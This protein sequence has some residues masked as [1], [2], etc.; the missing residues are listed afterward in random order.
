VKKFICIL[1][2]VFLMLG[3]VRAQADEGRQAKYEANWESLN[4]RPTPKW[5]TNAKFGIFIHWGVYAVPSWGVKGSYSEWYWKRVQD[6]RKKGGKWWQFHVQNY[7]EDFEYGDF[8]PM[9]KAELFD[10]DQWAQ[11]FRDSGAKYVVLTSKHHDGFC[12]WQSKEANKT[13]GRRWNS[14]DIGPRRDLLGDLG[15]AVRK[16]GLKMGFYY[17]LYEWFNPLWLTDKSRYIEEHLHPQFKDV[18]R[19]YKPSVIFSDGEWDLPSSEWKSEELLAWLFNESEARDD[20]VINDRWGKG[21]RHKHGG[22]YTTEYGAGLKG[23]AHPWE[24]NRG[25]GHSFGYNRAENLSDY[26][27]ARELILMLIDL[28]SRG[29][30]LLL[31]IGPTGDGR[32][33]VIMEERLIQMGDWLK[34]NGEAIYGT[35]PWRQGRQWSEGEKPEVGYGKTYKAKYDINTLT[36]KPSDGRA[37]IKA[38]FTSKGNTLYA[39][40]PRWPDRELVLEEVRCSKSTVVT[41]LGTQKPLRWKAEN[42]NLIIRIPKLSVDE[43]PCKHAYVLKL[44]NVN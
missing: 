9:F 23:S 2:A 30:N 19:R 17:S 29:G 24:E 15:E 5:W 26:K 10:P 14:V 3:V 25:M 18:V 13:W 42:G 4:T 1:S 22:Y 43:V 38:F 37:V 6:E 28:V 8:A 7:G 31:D 27:S 39:I 35:S 21:I 40:T 36:G 32:I 34:V 41:M 20:V 33:P 11:V 44:T 12:L 16:E